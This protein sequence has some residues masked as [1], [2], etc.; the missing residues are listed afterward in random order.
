MDHAVPVSPSGLCAQAT[1][2]RARSDQ[3]CSSV[4]WMNSVTSHSKYAGPK[5]I[6]SCESAD[7]LGFVRAWSGKR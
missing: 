6:N 4:F 1:V 3:G 7:A 2:E 5:I